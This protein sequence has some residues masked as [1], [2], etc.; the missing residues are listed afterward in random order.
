MMRDT[1]WQDKDY[2]KAQQQF[3]AEKSFIIFSVCYRVS[4][5]KEMKICLEFY[6]SNE[7]SYLRH[8]FPILVGL[9]LAICLHLRSE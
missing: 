9:I 2:I 7:N 1:F 4:M 3:L 5:M 6:I 8:R